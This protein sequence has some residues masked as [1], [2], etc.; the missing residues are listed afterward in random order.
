M[1]PPPIWPSPPPIRRVVELRIQPG[2]VP[3]RSYDPSS[4]SRNAVVNQAVNVSPDPIQPRKQAPPGLLPARDINRARPIINLNRISSQPRNQ[5]YSYVPDMVN[6]TEKKWRRRSRLA[7][8]GIG[9]SLIFLFGTIGGYIYL[10]YR[11]QFWLDGNH[12]KDRLNIPKWAHTIT[13]L[14]LAMEFA[15]VVSFCMRRKRFK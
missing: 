9:I 10:L 8:W 4:S 3:T 2:P 13:C 6:R 7:A 12:A 1:Q 14:G 5:N 11:S 15:V